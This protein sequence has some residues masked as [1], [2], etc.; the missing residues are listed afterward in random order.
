M[1]L[2]QLKQRGGVVPSAP[3]PHEVTWSHTTPEGE[4]VDDTFTIHVRRRSYGEVERGLV[5]DGDD[6]E[7]SRGAALISQCVF[8]GE[9]GVESIS[10]TD[11]Y[12]LDPSLAAVLMKAIKDVNG[13]GRTEPKN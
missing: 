9:G 8:F 11:A 12:Q 13:F 3:I 5:V 2:D 6:P 4:Q 10:Y 7:K 1:N